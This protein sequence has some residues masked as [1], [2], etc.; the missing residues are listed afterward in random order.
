MKN[1]WKYKTLGNKNHYIQ[2]I[3]NKIFTSQPPILSVAKTNI[4]NP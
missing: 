3:F 2:K 1:R 4:R